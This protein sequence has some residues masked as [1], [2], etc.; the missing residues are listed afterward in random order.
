MRI[1]LETESYQIVIPF[2]RQLYIVT[3]LIKTTDFP[4]ISILLLKPRPLD[5]KIP[6]SKLQ[7][8]NKLQCSKF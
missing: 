1:F 8:S 3:R 2:L 5:E 7:I 6:I 4:I